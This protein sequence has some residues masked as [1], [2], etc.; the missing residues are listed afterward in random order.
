MMTK[1]SISPVVKY[2]T[3][4]LQAGSHLLDHLRVLLH[5]MK[6]AVALLAHG[7]RSFLGAS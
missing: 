6:E 5:Y 2:V 3:P 7:R 1:F 4:E